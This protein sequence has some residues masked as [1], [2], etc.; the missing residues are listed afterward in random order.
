MANSSQ[1]VGNIRGPAGATGATGAAGPTGQAGATGPAGAAGNAGARGAS[2]FSG[3]GAPSS[4]IIGN[5]VAGQDSYIDLAS[6][7]TYT[8]S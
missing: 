4:S 6:G 8:F 3:T 5:A 7:D 1:K 2:T